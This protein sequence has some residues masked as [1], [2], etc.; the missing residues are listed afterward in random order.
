MGLQA[1]KSEYH[2]D[3]AI[4]FKSLRGRLAF[5]LIELLVVVTIIGI[6]AGLAMPA[7][8]GALTQAKRTQA[9]SMVANVKTALNS[10][11]TEYGRWPTDIFANET[12]SI[13]S[14]YTASS[15]SLYSLLTGKDIP[16][17]ANPHLT[18]F[19][20]FNSKELY[21]SSG[22]AAGFKD[23]WNNPYGI[24][25]DVNYDNQIV[26]P[27]DRTLSTNNSTATTISAAIAIWTYGD[28]ANNASG[29]TA[30]S[31]KSTAKASKYITSW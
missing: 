4:A 21:Y 2:F 7:L 13:S 10:Y 22:S 15:S 19:M 9:A 6:L 14:C 11:Q 8:N 5:T 26:V 29:T 17:G 27:F 16:S 28:Q 3:M 12:A 25:L 18:S 30:G 1:A 23:P 31:P 20:E 24:M